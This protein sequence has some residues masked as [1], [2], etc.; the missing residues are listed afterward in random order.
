MLQTVLFFINEGGFTAQLLVLAAGFLVIVS[1]ERFYVLYVQFPIGGQALIANIQQFIMK[2]NYVQA[3]QLCDQNFNNPTI[4]VV[5]QGLLAAEGGREALK[6]ALG[7]ALTDVSS[8]V[9]NRIAYLSLIASSATLLGLLG[10]I[11]G[12][13]KTFAGLAALD[14]TQKAFLLG[15]GISEAMYSTGAGLVV[16]LIAMVVHTVFKQRALNIKNNS[17]QVSYELL[18]NIERAERTLNHG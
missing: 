2:K 12:L 5:R 16:G 9:E 11:S 1:L 15:K 10:T 17:R 13:I 18:K 3:L 7:S 14:P 6:S 4:K 8:T